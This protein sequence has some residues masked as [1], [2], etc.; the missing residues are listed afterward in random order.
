[1]APFLAA[2]AAH[3]SQSRAETDA[4]SMT[5]ADLMQRFAD[6]KRISVQRCEQKVPYVFVRSTVRRSRDYN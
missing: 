4:A 2:H 6:K 1:M 3:P 5:K